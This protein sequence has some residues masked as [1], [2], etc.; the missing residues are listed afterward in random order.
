[1]FFKLKKNSVWVI[2]NTPFCTKIDRDNSG[3]FYCADDKIRL[4]I[5]DV[6]SWKTL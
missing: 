4:F 3:G 6:F 1:M 2:L 5:A